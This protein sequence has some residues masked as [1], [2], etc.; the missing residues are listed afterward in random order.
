MILIFWTHLFDLGWGTNFGG[1]KRVIL[2]QDQ[3]RLL[4]RFP[5]DLEI[6]TLFDSI[7]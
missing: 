7:H 3:K 1:P 6:T 4:K 5:N 2:H